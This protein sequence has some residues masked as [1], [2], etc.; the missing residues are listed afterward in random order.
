MPGE[1]V[2]DASAVL[3][4]LKRE[5]GCERALAVLDRAVISAVNVAEVQSKLIESGL[6]R[7]SA[8]A[9]FAF[10]GCQAIPFDEFLAFETGSLIERTRRCGLSLGD[11]A[12]L[13]LAL[14][15]KAPVYT[16]DKAWTQLG[17][18]LEIEVIR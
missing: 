17:I 7:Q 15:R 6:D 9:R 10:L 12:C 8:W 18:D 5:Q 14:V 2:F 16:T 1:I 13:A 3:T 4:I 11:R